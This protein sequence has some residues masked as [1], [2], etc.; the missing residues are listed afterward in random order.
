M[1]IM[2]R[3]VLFHGDFNACIDVQPR[4]DVDSLCWETKQNEAK[5]NIH[6]RRQPIWGTGE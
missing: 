1:Y 6:A 4:D 2:I 5:R 3:S